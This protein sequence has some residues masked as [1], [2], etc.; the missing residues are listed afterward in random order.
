MELNNSKTIDF[1]QQT[2]AKAQ[3]LAKLVEQAKKSPFEEIKTKD[4]ILCFSSTYVGKMAYYVTDKITKWS[5][6]FLEEKKAKTFLIEK[7]GKLDKNEKI[8][9]IID[10][11]TANNKNYTTEQNSYI[12]ELKKLL[13]N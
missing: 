8:N 6:I 10:Y 4:F 9:A 3:K 12:L 11:L 5:N 1:E 7:Y 13:E 2:T